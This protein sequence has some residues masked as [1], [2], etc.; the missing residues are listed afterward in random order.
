[1]IVKHITGNE[2]DTDKLPDVE[3]MIL[4]KAE[5]LRKICF[6]NNR[7]CVI[8]TDS[9]GMRNGGFTSFWNLKE[10]EAIVDGNGKWDPKQHQDSFNHILWGV[11]VFVLGLTNGAVTL[12]QNTP[13]PNE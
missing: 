11:N 7:Q 12:R 8:L 2:T 10:A 5:E 6:D 1:M 9:K 13:S 3:A 4:E